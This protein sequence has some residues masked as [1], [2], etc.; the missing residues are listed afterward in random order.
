M[1]EGGH[2]DMFESARRIFYFSRKT[3]TCA[4]K[5]GRMV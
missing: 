4:S 1:Q 5:R 2:V 3:W